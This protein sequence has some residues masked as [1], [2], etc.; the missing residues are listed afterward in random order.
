MRTNSYPCS[1]MAALSGGERGESLERLLHP[2]RLGMRGGRGRS[3]NTVGGET[4]GKGGLNPSLFTLF[5]KK[6]SFG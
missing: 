4:A 6:G 2:A 5:P 3:G 1:N